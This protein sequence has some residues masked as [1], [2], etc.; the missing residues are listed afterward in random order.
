MRSDIIE[1]NVDDI[2][3]EDFTFGGYPIETFHLTQ[4]GVAITVKGVT[5]TVDQLEHW[6]R[7]HYKDPYAKYYFGFGEKRSEIVRDGELIKIACLS[8]N[9]VEF[10]LKLNKFIHVVNTRG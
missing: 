9:Y 8:E 5:G 4:Y 2:A 3:N 10:K 7:N 6:L 1:I